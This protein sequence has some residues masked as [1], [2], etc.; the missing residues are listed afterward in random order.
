MY[1]NV[2]SIKLGI[3]GISTAKE[4]CVCRKYWHCDTEILRNDGHLFTTRVGRQYHA[5]E[6]PALCGE[7]Y[8][9]PY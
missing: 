8:D 4:V 1:A 9:D 5:A 3:M 2:F 6:W 7:H